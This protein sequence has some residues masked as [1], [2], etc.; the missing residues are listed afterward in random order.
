MGRVLGIARA[1]VAGLLLGELL[2][3]YPALPWTAPLLAAAALDLWFGRGPR[4]WSLVLVGL[5]LRWTFELAGDVT[6]PVYTNGLKPRRLAAAGA[7]VLVG[8][9]F[10]RGHEGDPR[11]RIHGLL[12]LP[13]AALAAVVSAASL[14]LAR[15][16]ARASACA[17]EDDLVAWLVAAAGV[18]VGSAVFAGRRRASQDRSA[19]LAPLGLSAAATLAM[20][21]VAAGVTSARG[22][23]ELCARIGL[24]P[25]DHGTLPVDLLLFASVLLVPAL[26]AGAALARARHPSTLGALIAG[27]AAGPLV[28]RALFDFDPTDAESARA[29]LGGVAVIAR[30]ASIAGA[31]LIA[32]C[33]FR[34]RADESAGSISAESIISGGSATAGSVTAG[35]WGPRVVL[36]VALVVA[37]TAV[38]LSP[39]TSQ[40][41]GDASR[42]RPISS[43]SLQSDSSP[44]SAPAAARCRSGATARG[45]TARD[46]RARMRSVR[47]SSV[48]RSRIRPPSTGTIG[49]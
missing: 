26:A 7:L 4:R 15:F 47:R 3:P 32:D 16:A 37:G 39:S 9:A 19:P 25:A 23:P 49:T 43:S 46:S 33:A 2:D 34:R 17:P 10:P 48:R 42:R 24:G 14:A 5:A 6:E 31:V 30:A 8:R 28:L 27:A 13:H 11:R 21:P 12:L 29:S 18:A 1:L 38:P 20:L 22:F 35:T 36:G 44:S 45:S 41:R 40:P